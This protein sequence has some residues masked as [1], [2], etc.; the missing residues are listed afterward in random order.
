MARIEI[1]SREIRDKGTFHS[2]FRRDLKFFGGY[3]RNMDAWIDC[4]T[5]LH[6]PTALSEL[7]LPEEEGIEIVLAEAEDFSKRCPSLF[8]AL[9]EC[10]AFVNQ[11]YR[12]RGSAVRVS[13]ILE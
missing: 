8:L 5:D 7:H 13:L 2:V 3:G 9:M 11:R 4:M 10:T 1:D 12:D 6:G